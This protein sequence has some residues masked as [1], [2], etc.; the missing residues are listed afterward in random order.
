[1][2]IAQIS[3]PHILPPGEKAYGVVATDTFLPPALARLARM[4]PRPDCVFLT[5]DLV[6]LGR[7]AEYRHLRGMLR[8][9]DLPCYLMPGNHD[10]RAR[11]IAA[12]PDHAYLAG[13]GGYIQYAVDD[14]AL[15]VLALDTVVPGHGHG[16]LCP[17]RLDWLERRLAEQPDRPTA[18]AMHHPPFRTGIAHMD[19][20][21]LLEGAPRLESILRS[22][23]NVVR[24]MCGH[25]HRT[26]FRSFGG[27]V[28]STCP[29]PAHQVTLDLLPDAPATFTMEPPG[30]HL[31]AWE[32]GELVTHHVA[33]GDYEGP[34]PF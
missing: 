1:M 10:D 12:F 16:A 3:D 9:L 29:S 17:A 18:V 25:V 30:L 31:H 21:G 4:R 34:Y 8:A 32:D 33:I 23:D 2:L 6:D 11:L 19:E 15:R 24:V 20:I 7:A 26:M 14:Y 27:T 5:G 28:A 13:E 22:Y